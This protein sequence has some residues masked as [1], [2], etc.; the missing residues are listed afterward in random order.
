MISP[1]EDILRAIVSLQNSNP[2]AW[3]KL[4]G[5]FSASHLGHLAV[6]VRIKDEVE[7]RWMDGRC[8]ELSDIVEFLTSAEQVIKNIQTAAEVSTADLVD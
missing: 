7:A 6:S 1:S 2:T 5:W 3:E 4:I 8:Q